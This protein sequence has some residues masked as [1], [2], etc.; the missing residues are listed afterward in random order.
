MIRCH[1][2]SI[3]GHAMPTGTIRAFWFDRFRVV[4]DGEEMMT[5][6]VKP[7][8]TP[9][10]ETPNATG[11]AA[12]SQRNVRHGGRRLTTIDVEIEGEPLQNT[13]MFAYNDFI[14]GVTQNDTNRIGSG[15]SETVRVD[16]GAAKFE[17]VSVPADLP[18][19]TLRALYTHLNIN[20]ISVDKKAC[21]RGVLAEL[22]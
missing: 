8:A 14:I 20:F 15:F 19:S 3:Y 18:S 1:N 2:T 12:K 17:M 7:V 6:E 11:T 16:I 4:V 5:V 22:L 21:S 10:P 9:E 13:V